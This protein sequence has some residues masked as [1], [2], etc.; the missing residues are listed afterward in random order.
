MDWLAGWA[1]A[2]KMVGAMSAVVVAMWFALVGLTGAEIA[3]VT[4]A[5]FAAIGAAFGQWMGNRSRKYEFNLN[6]E[7]SEINRTRDELLRVKEDLYRSRERLDSVRDENL[8]LEKENVRI[9]VAAKILQ[10]QLI[11]AEIDPDAVLEKPSNLF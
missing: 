5:G 1:A 11:E 7:E 3:T 10:G 9:W 6:R 8:A 2:H 4:V